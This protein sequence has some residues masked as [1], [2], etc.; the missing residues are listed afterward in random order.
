MWRGRAA[1]QVVG[2]RY[3][4]EMHVGARIAVQWGKAW[5]SRVHEGGSR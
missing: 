4:Y 3:Q 5:L 2:G 1:G